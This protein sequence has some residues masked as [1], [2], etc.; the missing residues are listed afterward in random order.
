MSLAQAPQLHLTATD[1]TT[2]LNQLLTVT[3]AALTI[4]A[5]NQT[6]SYGNTL[7]F[8]GIEFT[9]SAMYNGD[10]VTS[11]ALSSTGAAASAAPGSYA[12][13]PNQPITGNGS[14]MAG[15]YGISF[16]NGQLTVAT[17]SDATLASLTTS[18]GPLTSGWTE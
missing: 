18:S 3:P 6:K 13:V 15:N 2:T 10:A 4:T 12:I 8:A 11:V 7:T 16:V 14:F 1:G 17:S 5:N 9:T